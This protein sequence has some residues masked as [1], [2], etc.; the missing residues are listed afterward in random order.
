MELSQVLVNLPI[1]DVPRCT[2]SSAKT[3]GQNHLQLPDMGT[4][5]EPPD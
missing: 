4:G 2:T 1:T 5:G 3:L